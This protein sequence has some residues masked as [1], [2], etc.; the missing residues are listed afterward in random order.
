M[1]ARIR[2]WFQ[3]SF[4]YLWLVALAVYFSVLAG[5]AIYRNYNAQQESKALQQQLTTAQEEKARLQSLVIYYN[6]DAFREKELRRALLL[7]KPDEKVYALP[8]SAVGKQEEEAE[9]ARREQ[10]DPRTSLPTWK[11]WIQYLFEGSA[12]S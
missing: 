2:T 11:Q 8:E 1:F 10:E 5:Q 12:R 4:S 6:T 3:S 9:L 7:K